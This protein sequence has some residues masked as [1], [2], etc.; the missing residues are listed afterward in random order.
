M[1]A[2]LNDDLVVATAELVSRAGARLFE[3]GHTDD[4]DEHDDP[5]EPVTWHASAQY[6]GARIMTQGHSSPS[7]ACLALSERILGGGICKCGRPVTL[8]DSRPGCRW[9]LV[10][11][12]W[13]PGCDAPPILVRAKRGDVDAMRRALTERSSSS[14]DPAPG[15][16]RR[17]DPD[18]VPPALSRAQRRALRKRPGS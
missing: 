12:H 9:R 5:A 8:S 13:E 11:P 15:V 1:T 18:A 6:Q 10:G 7:A 2:D 16:L 17:V 3:L 14:S 4:D